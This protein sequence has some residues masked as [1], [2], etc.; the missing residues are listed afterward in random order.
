M[1]RL[2]EAVQDP[3]TKVRKGTGIV[4][5]AS[6]DGEWVVTPDI[7]ERFAAVLHRYGCD[8]RI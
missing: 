3:F 2:N 7:K 5:L 6:V 8:L 1:P 4:L